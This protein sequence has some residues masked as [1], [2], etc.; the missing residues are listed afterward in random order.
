LRE[1]IIDA[2]LLAAPA[3]RCAADAA[4][5]SQFLPEARRIL[6]LAESDGAVASGIATGTKDQD[7]SRSASRRPRASFMPD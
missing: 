1:H 5:R 3:A 2:P 6:K 4:G 7:R